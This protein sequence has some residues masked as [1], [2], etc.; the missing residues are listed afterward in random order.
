MTLPSGSDSILI[1]EICE[2][3]SRLVLNVEL[4]RRNTFKKALDLTRDLLPMTTRSLKYFF[5]FTKSRHATGSVIGPMLN[6]K[7]HCDPIIKHPK[8]S[9]WFFTYDTET[10]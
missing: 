9:T 6:W 2:Y 5:F 3:F 7:Q 10:P 8:L 4:T 1:L